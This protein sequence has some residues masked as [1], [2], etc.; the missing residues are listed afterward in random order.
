MDRASALRYRFFTRWQEVPM[1]LNMEGE[2]R[3]AA[4][5]QKVWEALNDPC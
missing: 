2:E 3:I 4:P 5:I 1:A